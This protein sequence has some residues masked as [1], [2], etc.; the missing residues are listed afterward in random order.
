[1]EDTNR[2]ARQQPENQ[3]LCPVCGAYREALRAMMEDGDSACKFHT[4]EYLIERYNLLTKAY[5]NLFCEGNPQMHNVHQRRLE[6]IELGKK[7]GLELALPSLEEIER[8]EK[9]DD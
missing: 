8:E 6:I 1:M 5:N 4:K 2:V 3:E 9:Q 7:V